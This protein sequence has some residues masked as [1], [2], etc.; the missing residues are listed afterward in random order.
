M[1]RIK[2]WKLSG[3]EGRTAETTSNKSGG[4]SLMNEQEGWSGRSRV[5]FG[6]VG[7]QWIQ[8]EG[9]QDVLDLESQA[10]SLD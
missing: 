5:T 10:E 4:G 2:A 7:S 9:N 3:G 6:E 1:N 8:L